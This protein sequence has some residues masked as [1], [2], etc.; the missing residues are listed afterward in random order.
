[1]LGAASRPAWNCRKASAAGRGR[2][3]LHNSGQNDDVGRGAIALLADVD[4]AVGEEVGRESGPRRLAEHAEQATADAANPRLPGDGSSHRRV[5][6]RPLAKARVD[7]R[8][9]T[10]E[11]AV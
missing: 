3:A 5:E 4:G 2:P 7:P 1:M 10:L 6:D 9:Q 8:Q 11:Q